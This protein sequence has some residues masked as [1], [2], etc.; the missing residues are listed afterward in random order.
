MS[1][2]LGRWQQAILAALEKSPM[3]ELGGCTHSE[4]SALL[5]AAKCL[6][7][8]GKCEIIRLWN[9]AHTRVVSL[10]ARPGQR[11]PDGRPLKAISVARVP[12]GTAATLTGSVRDIARSVKCSRMT[13]WRD[14]RKAGSQLPA[15]R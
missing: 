9:E 10:A 6:E 3:V 2:G 4:V 14:L 8:A 15:L 1:R 11:L 7:R 12:H 13:A 5:R